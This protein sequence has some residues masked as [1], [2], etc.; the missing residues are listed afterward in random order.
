MM[1]LPFCIY[2]DFETLNVKIS[3]CTPNPLEANTTDQT[4]HE[5]SGFTFHT[6]SD[7]YESKTVNYTGPTAF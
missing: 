4:R 3:K 2:A 5:V 7:F 6:V 1:K